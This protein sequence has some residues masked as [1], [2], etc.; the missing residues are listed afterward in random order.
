MTVGAARLARVVLL[1]IV[2]LYSR[3]KLFFR[4]SLILADKIKTL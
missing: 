3:G 4:K 1:L 2:F